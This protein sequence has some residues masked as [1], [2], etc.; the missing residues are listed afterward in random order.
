MTHR[1]LD[2]DHRTPQTK[3]LD[4]AM[5]FI[6][7]VRD[8]RVRNIKCEARA[9]LAEIQEHLDLDARLSTI[10]SDNDWERRRQAVAE[11][12]KEEQP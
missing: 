11:R 2:L 9:V 6:K 3:A 12:N 7:K 4:A 10:G 1:R 8:T 5:A